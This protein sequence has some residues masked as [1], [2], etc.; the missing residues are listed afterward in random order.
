V[1][2]K[3]FDVSMLEEAIFPMKMS[4]SSAVCRAIPI[5]NRKTI[6]QVMKFRSVVLSSNSESQW[7]YGKI[8][9]ENGLKI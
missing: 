7:N 5:L 9:H 8:E 6:A 4:K 1:P 3:N 2:H